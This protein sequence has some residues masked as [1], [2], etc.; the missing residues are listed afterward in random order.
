M[1]DSM[2][3]TNLR[4]RHRAAGSASAPVMLALI[5]LFALAGPAEMTAFASTAGSADR[6]VVDDPV[7]I[8]D[9]MDR[10]ESDAEDAE[11]AFLL[12]WHFAAGVKVEQDMEQAKRLLDRARTVW[13]SQLAAHE[14][15]AMRDVARSML[16]TAAHLAAHLPDDGRTQDDGLSTMAS[17]LADIGACDLALQLARRIDDAP[18]R[19]NALQL[20]AAPC[21]DAEVEPDVEAMLTEAVA[22]A[23]GLDASS[24]RAMAYRQLASIYATLGH[25]PQAIE[26]YERALGEISRW[27]DADARITH[28][29]R[30]SRSQAENGLHDEA[31]QSAGAA[32][33][34]VLN[35]TNAHERR[36][37]LD[38]VIDHQMSNGLLEDAESAIEHVISP[39]KRIWFATRLAARQH[40]RGNAEAVDRLLDFAMREAQRMDGLYRPAIGTM[41]SADEAHHD[42]INARDRIS[43]ALTHVER[44]DQAREWIRHDVIDYAV[45]ELGASPE[46]LALSRIVHELFRAGA[47]DEAIHHLEEDLIIDESDEGAVRPYENIVGFLFEHAAGAEQPEVLE[48]LA[49][50]SVLPLERCDRLAAAAAAYAAAGDREVAIEL[51][52]EA[53][54]LIADL[55]DGRE[56]HVAIILLA[57]HR[58]EAGFID[59]AV[60][61]ADLAEKQ[62]TSDFVRSR[63]SSVAAS[64]GYLDA[65]RNL[66]QRVSAE[67]HRLAAWFAIAEAA[68]QHDDD[69]ALQH[70]VERASRMLPD[71]SEPP[72]RSRALIRIAGLHQW[73]G[74]T[75]ALH[76]TLD[77]ARSAIDEM[78][79]PSQRLPELQRLYEAEINLGFHDRAVS[80]IVTA[81]AAAIDEGGSGR[82]RQHLRDSV[83]TLTELGAIDDA[84][85]LAKMLDHASVSD[86]VVIGDV[87]Q[88]SVAEGREDA[89]LQTT[90]GDLADPQSAIKWLALHARNI[91]EAMRTARNRQQ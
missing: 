30:T 10:I 62:A 56:Q 20:I 45:D 82:M 88:K 46:V 21:A 66:A 89:F 18:R 74:D 22:I 4:R 14:P 44:H 72:E 58:I 51:L 5:W 23:E 39:S 8:D 55:A 6:A 9:L 49:R 68:T 77:Q 64:E 17:H 73:L 61:T 57:V 37:K 63:I 7:A 29:L 43:E 79:P 47:M 1:N 25:T 34:D 27:D 35:H 36:R 85:D 33:E 3:D 2:P 90:A 76:E 31:S 50:L 60:A 52:R 75:D 15:D 70:A 78:D 28:R 91:N 87:I 69:E 65:A 40:D 48:R 80:T 83:S 19:I 26:Q 54:D 86:R 41:L 11:A 81:A 32:L 67:S 13:Q 38:D 16:A 84:Q 53:E 59:D 42:L 71:I 24:S 12:G